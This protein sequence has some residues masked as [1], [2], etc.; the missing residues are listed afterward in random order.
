M[1]GVLTYPIS[2]WIKHHAVTPGID[3][4]PDL[5]AEQMYSA[6]SQT[7]PARQWSLRLQMFMLQG[8]NRGERGCSIFIVLSSV[9]SILLPHS[10]V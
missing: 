8:D 2:P 3:L 10:L 6:A 5:L 4:V 1:R 7:Q 9:P